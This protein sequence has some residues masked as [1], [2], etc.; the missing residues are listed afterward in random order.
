MR[1]VKSEF[2][3]RS[4]ASGTGSEKFGVKSGDT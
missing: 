4:A 2:V 1:S 3:L